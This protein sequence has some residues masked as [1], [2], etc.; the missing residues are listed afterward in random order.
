MHG[1]GNVKTKL[2]NSYVSYFSP[3]RPIKNGLTSPFW[4]CISVPKISINV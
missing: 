4:K 2:K 1:E 3:N